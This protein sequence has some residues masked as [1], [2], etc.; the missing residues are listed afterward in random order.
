MVDIEHQG[1]FDASLF[2]SWL[3]NTPQLKKKTKALEPISIQ[4]SLMG[5]MPDSNN[6]RGV[7]SQF[8]VAN[9]HLWRFTTPKNPKNGGYMGPMGPQKSPDTW[10]PY[11]SFWASK[12]KG[13]ANHH[14][15]NSQS[16]NH[17]FFGPQVLPTKISKSRS[18]NSNHRI[19]MK[20]SSYGCFQK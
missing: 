19:Y 15:F 1:L 16:P 11:N 2:A 7:Q 18:T 13:S 17:Q 4:N 8:Y 5:S 20:I 6:N 14:C 9:H 12:V 3:V 10:I